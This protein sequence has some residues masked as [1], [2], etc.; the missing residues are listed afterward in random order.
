MYNSNSQNLRL[1]INGIED[2][3]TSISASYYDTYLS[4]FIGNNLWAPYDGL[5]R[6]LNGI[7]DEL[8]VSKI[9]KSSYWISTEYNNQNDPLSFY[10]FGPE[11]SAP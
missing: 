11:E 3:Y 7:V 8:Q 10:N 9:S 4:P 2:N 5:Y 1:F 6:P